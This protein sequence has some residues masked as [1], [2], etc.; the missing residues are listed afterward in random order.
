MPDPIDELEGFTMPTATPLPPGEVRRRGDRIRR[1]NHLLAAAGGVAVV[2]LI[3]TPLAVI[4]GHQGSSA[5][6]PAPATDWTTTVPASFD[7]TAVPA[8]SPVRFQ[9]ADGSAIDDF[10]LCGTPSFSTSKDATDTAGAT[11]GEPNTSSSAA[12]TVAVFPDDRTAARQVASLRQ[13]VQDCPQDRVAGTDYV[14]GTVD[15]TLPADESLVL[16]QQVQFDATTLSDL[17]LIEVARIGNAVFIGTTHTTAA[18]DQAIQE[19]LPALTSLSQPVLDQMCVFSATGCA[20]GSPDASEAVDGPTGL[21]GTIPDDFPLEV[22]L[23]TGAGTMDGPA[24]EI[25]LAPYNLE[26]NLRACGTAPSGLPAPVDTFYAGH[27]TPA[28]G[29]LRTLMTFG[30]VADAQAYAEGVLVVFA[31]CPEDA[32]GGVS[33][34]YRVTPGDLGDYAASA[35]MRVEVDGQP[36]TGYQV[37]QLVRVG[38]AVLQTLVVN[39]GDT[40]DDAGADQTSTMLLENSQSVVDAM[41]G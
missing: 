31:N 37:V 4:A 29:H 6:Q 15:A 18:G 8:G 34:V 38:Q 36:G 26:N 2:A 20:P 33:K 24:H 19:T 41:R 1:R 17:T 10:H 39:D 32:A 40:I 5:P 11:Y 7:V 22:G 16:S 30:S 25:D 3:A 12:R 35:V 13:S 28:E 23:P 21:T 9:D 14:W 27:R